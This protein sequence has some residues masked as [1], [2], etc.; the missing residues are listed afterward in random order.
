[1][2]T[3]SATTRGPSRAAQTKRAD[4]PSRPRWTTAHRSGTRSPLALPAL[5]R[6][7]Q[8]HELRDRALAPSRRCGSRLG[9]NQ[10]HGPGPSRQ[11]RSRGWSRLLT[12][13]MPQSATATRDA[14]LRASVWGCL[15][16]Q[17]WVLVG[18]V[19]TAQPRATHNLAARPTVAKPGDGGLVVRRPTWTST[20]ANVRWKRAQAPEVDVL[21]LRETPSRYRFAAVSSR[22]YGV[23]LG[24][25]DFV[26]VHGDVLSADTHAGVRSGAKIQIPGGR[27]GSAGVSGNHHESSVRG[28]V[29]HGRGA[30]LSGASSH[31]LQQKHGLAA[32]ASRAA[33]RR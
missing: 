25:M 17:T 4:R 29:L 2:H 23:A 18:A 9:A 32:D 6:P 7:R 8:R 33:A 11:S 28:Q 27:T 14:G 30:G 12:A 22:P 1:V 21:P 26:G 20:P 24:V 3:R 5:A 10:T 15:S 13:G 31:R 16:G 19:T